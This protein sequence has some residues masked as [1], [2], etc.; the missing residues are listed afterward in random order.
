MCGTIVIEYSFRDGIQNERQPQPGL[1]F[2]GTRRTCFLPDDDNGR[3]ALALLRRAFRAGVLF[4]VGDS[5]TTGAASV[6]VWGGIH[7]KTSMTGGPTSHGWPDPGHLDRLR[8]ECMALN[9][10]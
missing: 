7:Q 6:V 4:R 3:E 5:V 8:S 9:V 1:P 2:R 10:S